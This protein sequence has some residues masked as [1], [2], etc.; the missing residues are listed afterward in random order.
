[1]TSFMFISGFKSVATLQALGSFPSMAEGL[2]GKWQMMWGL[3]LVLFVFDRVRR[4]SIRLYFSSRF[5][6][7]TSQE[8]MTRGGHGI[9]Q[10]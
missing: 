8:R 3:G 5:S 1:M 4:N 6:T 7:S 2:G 10:V 9:L